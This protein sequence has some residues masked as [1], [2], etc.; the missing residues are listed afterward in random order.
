M[1][2]RF[3]LVAAVHLFLVKDQRILL[4]RRFNTG[5]EDGNYSVPAGHL[6]GNERATT[7]M[8]REAK[9]ETNLNIK[10]QHLS[11]VHIMH[12]KKLIEERIDFFFA[13]SRW[14]GQFK[15]MELHKCDDL[16][17]F[18]LK[19]LPANMVPYVRFGIN[20]Y[21]QGNLYSE[22]GWKGEP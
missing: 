15:I 17:R 16:R 10:R 18:P 8:A 1:A 11:L 19:R 9:E 3:Q 14:T 12:R 20:Q 6:D 4:L 13:A 7:A 2:H 21:L 22:Y 5:Y